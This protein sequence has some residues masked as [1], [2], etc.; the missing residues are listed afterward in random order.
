MA[1]T[2][3]QRKAQLRKLGS[4]TRSRRAPKRKSKT[5]FS[6]VIQRSL[7]TRLRL[8]PVTATFNLKF[9]V[10][11][12]GLSLVEHV[13]SV[14]RKICVALPFNMVDSDIFLYTDKTPYK[15]K[16][17]SSS[18]VW[19]PSRDHAL[20]IGRSTESNNSAVDYPTPAAISTSQFPTKLYP[21]L[22]YC[23]FWCGG[24]KYQWQPPVPNT[25]DVQCHTAY[26][27]IANTTPQCSVSMSAYPAHQLIKFQDK[28]RLWGIQ[29]NAEIQYDSAF[30]SPFNRPAPDSE[31]PHTGFLKNPANCGRVSHAMANDVKLCEAGQNGTDGFDLAQ[32]E[33]FNM[34]HGV[35]YFIFQIAIR[36]LANKTLYIN[37]LSLG[38]MSIK[39]YFWFDTQGQSNANVHYNSAQPR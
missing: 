3:A 16:A 21:F 33:K 2:V 8:I 24:M 38:T 4:R 12:L 5:P 26:N 39:R 22:K 9:N 7:G 25:N 29:D 10:M 35:A 27:T 13:G 37:Q 6:A 36:Q 19:L 31:G 17:T 15:A 34:Q 23:D 20:L 14:T 18:D 28:P 11:D 30:A 1:T 32:F